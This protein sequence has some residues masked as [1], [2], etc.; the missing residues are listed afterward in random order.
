MSHKFFRWSH[1]LIAL[2]PVGLEEAKTIDLYSALVTLPK[3]LD[4][5]HN[6]MDDEPLSELPNE[7]NGRQLSSKELGRLK[8]KKAMLARSAAMEGK[9][10][11]SETPVEE[12]DTKRIK[13]DEGQPAETT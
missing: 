12:R 7:K 11:Q 6:A 3:N 1:P 5:E 8:S 10:E 9:R 4:V 13:P 2:P